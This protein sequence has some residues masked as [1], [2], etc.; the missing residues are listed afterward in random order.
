MA[1]YHRPSD[2][3]RGGFLAWSFHIIVG[4]LGVLESGPV[5]DEGNLPLGL[6]A[7]I[8]LWMVGLWVL[9]RNREF[10]LEHAA[11]NSE[12]GEI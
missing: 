4:F 5:K 7:A 2:R 1:D 6:V 11:P 3:S 12:S 8:A 9:Y 10:F